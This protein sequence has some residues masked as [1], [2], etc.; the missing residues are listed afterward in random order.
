MSDFVALSENNYFMR[1]RHLIISLIFQVKNRT[2]A[3]FVAGVF[4]PTT[5]KWVMKK[6]VQMAVRGR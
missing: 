4:A 6:S 2:L 1:T 5:I 3:N